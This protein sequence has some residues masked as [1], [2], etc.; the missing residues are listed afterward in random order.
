MHDAAA[1][2]RAEQAAL[3]AAEPL[4]LMEAAGLSLARLA[5]ALVPHARQVCV[6]AGPG[7][8][9]GDGLVAARHLHASGCEVRVLLLQAAGQRP[10]DAL[11]A[12]AKA[13]AAGV[14]LQAW[15]DT[16]APEI[17]KTADLHIDALLGLGARRAPQG[18]MA[19]AITALNAAADSGTPVLAADLPSG[20]HPD[21]GAVLGAAA[22]C[23]TATLAL[24]SLKPGCHTA[25]GRDHAGK[26]WLDVL[27]VPAGPPTA[28]LAGPARDR[29]RL[30]SSH[31]GSHGDVVVVGGAAGMVG[32][33][34]LAARA[35]LAAGAG[36]VFCSLLDEQA[37]LLDP[38]QAALMGRHRWW[39]SAP[40][41]LASATVACGCGGGADIQPALPALLAHVPRLVLDADALNAI[42]GDASLQAR[43]QSRAA[44][45]V[46]TV[47]TPHPLEAAR[48]LQSTAAAVQADRLAA[49]QTL[50]E[51]YAAVV[52]LKGS[53]TV[54]AAP[55]ALPCVNSS[56]N[57]S[58]ASAGTGDVLAGW[59]AGLWSQAPQASV[60]EIATQAVWQHGRAADIDTAA[61]RGAPMTA[62]RLIEALAQ[63]RFD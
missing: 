54:L 20:L 47:L 33:A 42:A 26:V 51:R 17:L 19:A 59:V 16:Q 6:W 14:A 13:V 44:H 63:R 8:N 18:A 1:S 23:A 3:G 10:A 35:A 7:N 55:G 40:G 30:H 11:R 31:K 46:A 61:A 58:L 28:W 21:T 62:S 50:A 60:M 24:L 15:S 43:L 57:A 27:G 5:L 36:R 34:W 53:G 22:V 37:S 32:A 29:P 45:G 39:A 9:G 49:A 56:G 52:V 4:A 25:Q 12:Q 48:L 2:R 38:M 41:T